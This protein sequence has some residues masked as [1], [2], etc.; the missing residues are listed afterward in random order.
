M[1]G[2]D[3]KSFEPEEGQD[4][5]ANRWRAKYLQQKERVEELKLEHQKALDHLVPWRG[6][7]N[8]ICKANCG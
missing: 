8:A 7:Q 3:F 4:L 1:T 6:S 5:L 2:S